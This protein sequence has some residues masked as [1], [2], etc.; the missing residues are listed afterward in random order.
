M[1]FKKIK[2]FLF[3]LLLI[4][5]SCREEI[6]SPDNPTGNINEPFLTRTGNSYIFSINA[7]NITATIS[8]NTF[9]NT[10]KSNIYS[11]I[12][13]YSSGYVEVEVKTSRNSVLYSEVFEND[14]RGTLKSINGSQ[15]EIIVM[16]FQNFTG[17]LKVT[18]SSTQ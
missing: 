1:N 8:D 11:I 7:S 13:D 10:V 4:F 6:I 17:K 15:P 5:F 12:A 14:T 3:S 2:I 9:L 18:L 16:N